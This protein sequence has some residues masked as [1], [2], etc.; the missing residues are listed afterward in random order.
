MQL[1]VVGLKTGVLYWPCR[2]KPALKRSV[3]H[4][5]ST[6]EV[7][8]SKRPFGRAYCVGFHGIPQGNL[9]VFRLDNEL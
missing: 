8:F 1:L 7:L 6:I 5:A 3:R 4:S 9:D 2:S